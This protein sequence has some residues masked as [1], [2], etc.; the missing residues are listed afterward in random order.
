LDGNGDGV[1]GDDYVFSFHRLFGDANGDKRVDAADF[2]LFRQVFGT[3]A[4]T[5]DFN[6]DGQTTSDDFAEFR[7]RFGLMI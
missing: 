7:K 4:L 3:P 2:A 6:N 5:F 1:G